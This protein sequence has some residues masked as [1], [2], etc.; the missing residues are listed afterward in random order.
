M[1]GRV[2]IK[3]GVGPVDFQ[4]TGP[5]GGLAFPFPKATNGSGSV[6]EQKGIEVLASGIYRLQITAAPGSG[7]LAVAI[8]AK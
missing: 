2:G 6:L 5:E 4:L 7:D 1:G 8:R 3:I